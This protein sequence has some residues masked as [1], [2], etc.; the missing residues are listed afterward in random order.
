[1]SVILEPEQPERRKAPRVPVGWVGQYVIPSRP[2]L[3]WGECLVLDAS[4]GGIG[5]MLFGPW[6]DG[7]RDELDVLVR[8]EPGAD[9]D[10]LEMLGKVRN[11]TPVSVGELRVGIEFVERAGTELVSFLGKF[12]PSPLG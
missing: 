4:E 9:A 1:M 6:P 2:D 10:P 11:Q 8:L 7:L 12:A 5:L 3:G